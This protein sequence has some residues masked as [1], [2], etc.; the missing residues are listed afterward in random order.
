MPSNLSLNDSVPTQ[1]DSYTIPTIFTQS[2]VHFIENSYNNVLLDSQMQ[3]F[4][5][6]LCK[7][8]SCN[9]G[10]WKHFENLQNLSKTNSISSD[11]LCKY[12]MQ[13]SL[14]FQKK[15]YFLPCFY[16]T[17][18]FQESQSHIFGFF[19]QG[20]YFLVEALSH[21]TSPQEIATLALQY[22]ISLLLSLESADTACILVILHEGDSCAHARQTEIVAHSPYKLYRC[23]RHFYFEQPFDIIGEN[24]H[25]LKCASLFLELRGANLEGKFCIITGDSIHSL[26]L[27]KGLKLLH[28]KPLT[29]SNTTGVLYDSNGLD[30][31]LLETIYAQTHSTSVNSTMQNWL[32]IYA[33]ERQCDFVQQPQAIKEI[34]AFATFLAH[35]TPITRQIMQSLLRNGC[36]YIVELLPNLSLE[37]QRLV[38]D[39]RICYMPFVLVGCVYFMRQLRDMQNDTTIYF[40]ALLENVE[41]KLQDSYPTNIPCFIT[42]QSI[43]SFLIEQN[44]ACDRLSYE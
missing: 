40:R 4:L 2:I 3:F 11:E 22:A 24:Y 34:P 5:Q 13:D 9:M 31:E 12:F 17:V 20:D 15:H 43:F 6:K 33:H 29:L 25:L 10:T 27:A 19:G 16:N 35:K 44:M 1:S 38:L 21:T 26:L 39:S 7:M 32:E 8:E 28:A 41:Y 42:L 37:A 23:I 18:S 30:I 36:K 14:L